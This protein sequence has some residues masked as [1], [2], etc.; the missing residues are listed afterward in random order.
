MIRK[1]LFLP[2]CFGIQ[3]GLAQTNLLQNGSFDSAGLPH[4]NHWYDYCNNEITY[5]NNSNQPTCNGSPV[6]MVYDYPASNPPGD[7]ISLHAHTAQPG[8][9]GVR[10]FITGQNGTQIYQLSFWMKSMPAFGG[11]ASSGAAFIGKYIGPY[12]YQVSAD[13]TVWN[14]G[15]QHYTL[16]DTL[17]TLASDSIYVELQST[18]PDLYQGQVYFDNAELIVI[19]NISSAHEKKSEMLQIKVY[20]AP[21]HDNAVI[22]ITNDKKEVC[23]VK[24]F[25]AAG[26]QVK[27]ISGNGK[28]FIVQKE[29]LE[30]G[31]YFLRVEDESGSVRGQGKIIFEN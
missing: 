24:V 9:T 5:L 17:T 6:K 1:L 28:T 8:G 30:A 3:T 7:T 18:G 26:R 11:G 19:G 16:T 20:P 31:L 25:D 13:T 4:G 15:W 12:Q 29:E 27:I 22:E 14:S 21:A 23:I 2:L 10:Q